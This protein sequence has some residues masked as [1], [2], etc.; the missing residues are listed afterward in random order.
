M[1]QPTSITAPSK[2]DATRNMGKTSVKRILKTK[3]TFSAPQAVP[4]WGKLEI[5]LGYYARHGRWSRRKSRRP[6]TRPK[7]C[8]IPV[9][10]ARP[11]SLRRC[12]PPREELP[13]F[14]RPRREAQIIHNPQAAGPI[15]F[16]HLILSTLHYHTYPPTRANCPISIP[17]SPSV[18]VSAPRLLGN[19][20]SPAANSV[21]L[22][23]GNHPPQVS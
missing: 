23:E 15:H 9:V 11:N 13:S 7:A 16:K 4:L 2:I 6:T 3:V 18:L 20:A 19:Q 10:L 22:L 14:S 21:I 1:N 17:T 5:S 8:P 12:L